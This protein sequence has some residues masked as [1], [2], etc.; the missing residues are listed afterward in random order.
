[1]TENHLYGHA[2]LYVYL[3]Y[4]ENSVELFAMKYHTNVKITL[5][6]ESTWK[7]Y[8]G[9]LFNWNKTNA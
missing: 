5:C 8:D 3:V 4:V 1:M 7:A 2:L 9:L 6:R